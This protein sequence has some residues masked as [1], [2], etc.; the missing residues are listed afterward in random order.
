[1][2][3]KIQ[4]SLK[5]QF[6]PF[7]LTVIM[8]KPTKV[9]LKDAEKNPDKYINTPIGPLYEDFKALKAYLES[10]SK[11]EDSLVLDMRQADR[12][13]VFDKNHKSKK[14]LHLEKM[15]EK[16]KSKRARIKASLEANIKAKAES[17]KATKEAVKK[18]V[19]KANKADKKEPKAKKDAVKAEEVSAPSEKDA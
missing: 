13:H 16:S 4:S 12:G 11:K 8:G 1:M 18:A 15:L 6:V 7:F 2:R 3:A 5:K 19:A 10:R 17:E 9:S 14:D